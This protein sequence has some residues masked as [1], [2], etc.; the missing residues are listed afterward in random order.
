MNILEI[1]N[2]EQEENIKKLWTTFF[3]TIGIKERRNKRCQMNFM[4][5]KYWKYIIEMEGAYEKSN[6]R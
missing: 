2:N 5:K 3:N 4:P 1:K 6:N